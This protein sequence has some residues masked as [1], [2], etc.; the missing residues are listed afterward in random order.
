MSQATIAMLAQLASSPSEANKRA[1]TMSDGS[2][3]VDSIEA[4][5]SKA[6]LMKLE[7]VKKKLRDRDSRLSV[8]ARDNN[9][10]LLS[11]DIKP[12]EARHGSG[13][14][15]DSKEAV[16][17][18]SYAAFKLQRQ[19][20]KKTDEAQSLRQSVCELEETL[21]AKDEE[22]SALTTDMKIFR[23]SL[24][25]YSDQIDRLT[26]ELETKNKEMETL[27]EE[28]YHYMKQAQECKGK[29][30][31]SRKDYEWMR[32]E[33]IAKSEQ[34]EYFEYELLAKNDEIDKLHQEIDQ[35]LRRI[36]ELEVD[37]ELVDTRTSHVLEKSEKS[38]VASRDYGT[39]R[40][41]SAT[42][43]NPADDGNKH[44]ITPKRIALFR[45]RELKCQSKAEDPEAFA[46]MLKETLSG[47][48][49]INN[50]SFPTDRSTD[51][52]AVVSSITGFTDG[53]SPPRPR[54]PSGRRN[55]KS[56]NSATEQYIDAIDELRYD[57]RSIEEKYK[58]DRYDSTKLIE[59]LRQENN[60]YLIK[61][62][63]MDCKARNNDEHGASL[64]LLLDDLNDSVE[65]TSMFDGSAAS[66]ETPFESKVNMLKKNSL[67][68]TGSKLPNKTEYL[69][70]KVES[71]EGERLVN[72][73]TIED[74]KMKLAEL[75]KFATNRAK[76]D[77]RTIDD[78]VFQ[79]EA[80]AM[81]IAQLEQKSRFSAY[82]DS[83]EE[84]EYTTRLEDKVEKQS[85]DI[86]KLQLE[87]ELK[88][89]TIEALRAQ[90]VD[91][92][93]RQFNTTV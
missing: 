15:D 58:Q 22:N 34:I 85:V 5:K 48:E 64:S 72:E 55:H 89:R 53:S 17:V 24:E 27:T 49:S 74:L 40:P 62:V 61:L 71:M 80:Q 82:S 84:P 81:K 67:L 12:Y 23:R 39:V 8:L 50:G 59:K 79:N 83:D 46:R 19:V 70:R 6:R 3:S 4:D 75:E 57:L 45:L 42:T 14:D 38:L 33:S 1:G 69:Q 43:V 21:K 10:S 36:A 52:T 2:V 86:E 41:R 65:N 20:D 31:A 87:N 73:R 16:R 13:S 90:L 9:R 51:T 35:K 92:R 76:S 25:T 29:L 32:K 30:D 11:G 54:R 88:D 7:R 91:Q 18:L 77:K 26:S 37:L 28:H 78:L 66:T 60:E 56:S 44:Q 68:T 63:C 47:E 93:V